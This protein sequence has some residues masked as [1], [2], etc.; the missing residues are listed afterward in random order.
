[1]LKLGIY[2]KTQDTRLHRLY[3]RGLKSA[4][5][6]AEVGEEEAFEELL[7]CIELS[8]GVARTTSANR[9][10]RLD[11]EIERLLISKFNPEQRLIVEDCAVSSGA[12]SAAWFEVVKKDFP[13]LLFTAS[14][15]I[16]YLIEAKHLELG[17]SYI[18]QPDGTPIQYVRPPFVVSLVHENH[19]LYVVN[20]KIQR[21]ALEQ[22]A[23]LRPQLQLPR[24]W[25]GSSTTIES[26][27]FIFCK[28]PLINPRVLGLVGSNFR[29]VQRSIFAP[30]AFKA[31]VMRSMN[32]LN[33]SYFDEAKLYEAIRSMHESVRTGGIW[34]VGRTVDENLLNHEVT[35]F[36]RTERGW[37][38]LQREGKGSEIEPLVE[39]F[40]LQSG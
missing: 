1:M 39:S 21:D 35:I 37:T 2:K 13:D 40:H 19:C 28:L 5:L 15:S 24:E 25:H 20:R 23:R 32:I 11:Q 18:L 22:W 14:D 30:L 33:L 38:T 3:R 29:V 12:T 8:H 9:F 26:A 31:D 16:L 34:I 4:S 27:P 7:N 36:E 6:L 17:C 10:A